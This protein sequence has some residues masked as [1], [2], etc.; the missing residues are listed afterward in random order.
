MFCGNNDKKLF[1][2]IFSRFL[3]KNYQRRLASLE[4]FHSIFTIFCLAYLLT[5]TINGFLFKISEFFF[6]LKVARRITV[7]T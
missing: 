3:S 1:N 2:C 4:F 7:Y 6:D 5:S